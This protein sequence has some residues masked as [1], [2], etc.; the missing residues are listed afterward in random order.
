MKKRI[1]SFLLTIAMVISILP[2]M[3]YA[4]GGS[5]S[6]TDGTAPSAN[7]SISFDK[8]SASAGQT[9]TITVNPET[10]YQLKSLTVVPEKPTISIIADVL[11][12]IDGF[13]EDTS[14]ESKPQIPTNA[15]SNGN[16]D[17]AFTLSNLL[18]LK[19]GNTENDFETVQL[20]TEVTSGEN[21]Y[22]VQV[23]TGNL[24]FIMEDG[25]LVSFEYYAT[26]EN[27]QYDGTYAPASAPSPAPSPDVP[28]VKQ[29]DGTYTFTMP[30]A[31]VE[32]T[33][34]FEEI[35]VVTVGNLIATVAG[36]FPTTAENGWTSENGAKSYSDGQAITFARGSSISV[37][38]S[39]TVEK[40]GNNYVYQN[41]YIHLTF[42]MSDNVL[43]KV[44]VS[45]VAT[46][47]SAANGTY[48]PVHTHN[49]ITFTAWN[50]ADKLPDTAGYYYL[51][52]DVTL[53]DT[54]QVPTGTTNLCLNGHVIKQTASTSVIKVGIG[55]TLNL[56]DCGTDGTITGGNTDI[57]GGVY[58]NYAGTFN[59]YGGNIT[60]NTAT[61]DGGGGVY[62]YSE[63]NFTMYD[64]TISA[65][66]AT[67]MFGGGVYIDGS[68][69]MNGG[70]IDHNSAKSGGGVCV[71]NGNFTMTGGSI[72]HNSASS[73]GGVYNWSKMTVTGASKITDNS[74]TS[75]G[76][77]VYMYNYNNRGTITVGGSANITGNMKESGGS[78]TANDVYLSDGLYF[79]IDTDTNNPVN[80]M[81]IG[82]TTATAP[83]KDSPVKIT[84]NGTADDA[85]WFIP[86]NTD[87]IVQKNSE[88]N[89]L[90]LVLNT[91]TIADIIATYENFPLTKD[92][93]LYWTNDQGTTCYYYNNLLFFRY[94]T[95]KSLSQSMTVN[96]TAD[97]KNYT[98]SDGTVT[99]TFIMNEDDGVLAAITVS[100]ST[101]THYNGTYVAPPT[102]YTVTFDM[103]GHG[104]QVASQT[105]ESGSKATEPAVPTENGWKFGG[106]Y[107]DA[108]FGSAFN[109]ETA[110]TTDTII[111]AKWTEIAYSFEDDDTLE[112][113]LESDESLDYVVH[114]SVDDNETF[115]L[116][117]GIQVDDVDVSAGNYDAT[118]GS[119]IL[120]LKPSYL[121]TLTVGE[122]TLNVLFT[123]GMVSIKFE[124][125]SAEPAPTGVEGFVYRC[126]TVILGR[127]PEEAG[128]QN[129]M[130]ALNNKTNCGAQVAHGFIFSQEY[131][132]KNKSDE[133]F[134]TDLYL[135]FFG[136][137]PDTAGLNNWLNQLDT[138]VMT[139][140]Q[141]FASFAKSTEFKN[142]CSDYGILQGCYIEGYSTVSQTQV[143]LFVY[144]LY[145]ICLGR[146]A[147]I[148]GLENW[149]RNILAGNVSGYSAALGFFTSQEYENLNKSD[150]DFIKELYLVMM[151]RNADAAGL[152]NWVNQLTVYTKEEVIKMFCKSTEYRNIC[153]SYGINVGV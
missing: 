71:F 139:K 103:G 129:W 138:G 4:G 95:I 119:L 74:A 49:D 69:T 78:K 75:L 81:Q 135:M 147:D 142:I 136:R 44:I 84:T 120:N 39:G 13:P 146:D 100:G 51:N 110:I 111:Y 67:S 12:T 131:I 1:I 144:R 61:G 63:A 34:D 41:E 127:E 83:D 124:I 113:Q 62:V 65:N 10:G 70:S 38:L 96:V 130:N 33:A 42:V 27:V 145:N 105:V 140:E 99:Y 5:Y 6:I 21:C 64:G 94:T 43:E 55:A 16:D 89:Y 29:D 24:T 79:T 58:V 104:V 108:T 77:G 125:K 20:T 137:E 73:G 53:N 68:F 91:K 26:S 45:D 60:G 107:T 47:F 122:H 101:D 59:M 92:E 37:P 123:D 88:N 132:N 118:S 15:W 76:A 32:V 112:W 93:D 22:T 11:A 19:D 133:E 72:D 18:V 66:T 46:W 31:N 50:D 117:I 114:R 148:G 126:Y 17:C 8:T 106:W 98:Y 7:G 121:N 28:T 48:A 52:T 23:S 30:S 25:I 56:Y 14:G 150:E 82:V 143:N 90:E 102:K 54:W 115:S 149:S 40:S 153:A 87:C 80:G 97:G 109:F 128:M 151:D 57:G 2:T 116:F 35:P 86:N 152:K 134:V 36:G 3:V 141:V 9:V 85:K